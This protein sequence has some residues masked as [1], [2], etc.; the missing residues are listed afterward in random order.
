[1]NQFPN[2]QAFAPPQQYQPPPGQAFSPPYQNAPPQPFNA[3]SPVPFQ[4]NQYQVP[5]TQTPPQLPMRPGNLPAAPGLPQRPS[6]GAPP[7]NAFQMQQLHQ[8]QIPGPSN[9]HDAAVNHQMGGL[10]QY[11]RPPGSPPIGNPEGSY[12]GSTLRQ[13]SG[14]SEYQGTVSNSA[15]SLDDLLSGAAKEADKADTIATIKADV[16]RE[17]QEDKRAKKEKEKGTR[18]VY[19]D[20]D[21]SPEEKMAQMPRYAFAPNGKESSVSGVTAMEAV[22]VTT[23]SED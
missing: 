7:V 15:T 8:G 11:G 16:K 21:I 17:P 5:R 6:F 10:A 14:L 3:G 9:P 2:Q 1:M 13:I 22:T 4:P 12:V 20:N 23:G 18:L 19:S